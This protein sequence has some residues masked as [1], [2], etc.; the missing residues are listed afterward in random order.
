MLEKLFWLKKPPCRYQRLP[1]QEQRPASPS[2]PV[3]GKSINILS[4]ALLASLL[5]VTVLANRSV[6][7]QEVGFVHRK[8]R[9]LRLGAVWFGRVPHAA[10][11]KWE[12][13]FSVW[14]SIHV[15][16]GGVTS[17]HSEAP[18]HSQRRRGPQ[19]PW[20]NST[21]ELAVPRGCTLKCP[22]TQEL[23]SLL[24]LTSTQAENHLDLSF[25]ELSL[26]MVPVYRTFCKGCIQ[27]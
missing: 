25:L 22:R 14:L 1:K 21:G 13:R 26:F 18:K 16:S 8:T 3:L 9:M 17:Q 10:A 20:S 12:K 2:L 4:L 15:F 23:L 11:D 5:I 6:L 24:L 27:P 7:N 19:I